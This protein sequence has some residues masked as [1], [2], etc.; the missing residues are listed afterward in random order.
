MI[1]GL[2]EQEIMTLDSNSVIFSV[3]STFTSKVR[4]FFQFG[5]RKMLVKII[6][7]LFHC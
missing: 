1:S 3:N 5:Y 6:E 7:N 4:Y 2:T